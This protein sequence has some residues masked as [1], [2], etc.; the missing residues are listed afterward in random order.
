MWRYTLRRL[1]QVI[2]TLLGVAVLIFFFVRAIPGDPARAVAGA[3]ATAADIALIRSDL[4]LDKPWPVQFT[5]YATRLLHGDL[6][7]SIQTKRPVLQLLGNAIGPSTELALAAMAVAL[8]VGLGAGAQAAMRR[9]S[10]VDYVSMTLAVAGISMPSFWL[11][12][13]LMGLFAVKWRLLPTSGYGT[14]RHLVLPAVTLG[15][16][17]GAGIARFTRT[18]LLEALGQDYI[19]TARAKGVADLR[20]TVGHAL[21]NALIP[22]ITYAG[23]QFGFLLGGAVTV[24]AVFS[25]PGLGRLIVDGVNS[26]DYPLVQGLMLLFASQFVILNL[27]VDLL[28]AAVDP[29]ISYE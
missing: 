5:G 25:W 13:L 18:S 29:R 27:A 4:G 24:E 3:D 7:K 8:I 28:Y 15:T 17:A 9:N 11:G 14:W 12:L 16:A 23:L 21:R 19:R 6:G 22:V 2:P 10:M 26:R 1:L 20:A